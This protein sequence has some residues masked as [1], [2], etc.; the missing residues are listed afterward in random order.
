MRN[1]IVGALEGWDEDRKVHI[2]S[3]AEQVTALGSQGFI[4][5]LQTNW[6]I[7]SSAPSLTKGGT[8]HSR[9]AASQ[10][11]LASSQVPIAIEQPNW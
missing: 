6:G 10:V 4:M 2:Q 1:S 8:G 11:P 5:R 7:L 9:D 3:T